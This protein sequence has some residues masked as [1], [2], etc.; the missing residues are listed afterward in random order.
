[1]ELLHKDFSSH[2]SINLGCSHMLYMYLKSVNDRGLRYF[3]RSRLHGEM[4]VYR[5]IELTG[6]SN[7]AW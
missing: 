4:S 6:L 3:V 2:T 5:A 7:I 1:M